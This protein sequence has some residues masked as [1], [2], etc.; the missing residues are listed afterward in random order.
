MLFGARLRDCT[1]EEGGGWV[2]RFEPDSGVLLTDAEAAA[3]CAA[4]EPRLKE[5]LRR[6]QRWL[7]ERGV[8]PPAR[9]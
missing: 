4:L 1:R 2:I 6:Q 3:A 8:V 5:T 7:D 9:P